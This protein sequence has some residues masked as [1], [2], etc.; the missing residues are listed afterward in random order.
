MNFHE[1][2]NG[3]WG[4]LRIMGERG[5]LI[6]KFSK[7]YGE[8]LKEKIEVDQSLSTNLELVMEGLDVILYSLY[9]LGLILTNDSLDVRAHKQGTES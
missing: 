4:T 6:F 1:G 7:L 8:K 5:S 3:I 9:K 2:N